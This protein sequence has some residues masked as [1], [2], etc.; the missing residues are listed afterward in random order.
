MFGTF[1]DISGHDLISTHPWASGGGRALDCYAGKCQQY[2]AR[3][4]C[5][6]CCHSNTG[7]SFPATA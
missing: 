7:V 3:N 5:G 6:Y 4:P 2:L 1:S